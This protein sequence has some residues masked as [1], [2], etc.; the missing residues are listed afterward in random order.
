MLLCFD[1]VLWSIIGDAGLFVSSIVPSAPPPLSFHISTGN[2]G[3]RP[4]ETTGRVG[5]GRVKKRVRLCGHHATPLS[6]L[7]CSIRCEASAML[8]GGGCVSQRL[9]RYASCA[10]E[11]GC[12]CMAFRRAFIRCAWRSA[13]A[14]R[15]IHLMN[16]PQWAHDALQACGPV[17]GE[18]VG[19]STAPQRGQA[20]AEG[21]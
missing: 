19:R 1:T 3:S 10:T 4:M 17:P 9:A 13:G 6:R 20:S 2:M 14:C 16:F 11:G 8:V 7:S 15:L 18:S 5:Q 21:L 12:I